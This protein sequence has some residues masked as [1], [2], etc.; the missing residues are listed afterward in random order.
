MLPVPPLPD[1][2]DHQSLHCVEECGGRGKN[3]LYLRQFSAHWLVEH[4]FS[5]LIR[6]SLWDFLPLG[7]A[8]L[9]LWLPVV[10]SFAVAEVDTLSVP[11][12]V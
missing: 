9:G 1:E 7:L 11:L 4:L 8:L 2:L 6:S 10:S 12:N 3:S 5:F